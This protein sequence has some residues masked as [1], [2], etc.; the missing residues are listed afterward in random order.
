MSLRFLPVNRTHHPYI[1]IDTSTHS[2][3]R[4]YTICVV[5]NRKNSLDIRTK[6]E[7]G[8]LRWAEMVGGHRGIQ[9]E[10]NRTTVQSSK[11]IRIILKSTLCDMCVCVFDLLQP[12]CE[13]GVYN[14]GA[15]IRL[16]FRST[17]AAKKLNGVCV[18]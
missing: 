2:I 11:R 8:V 7:I 10:R 6:R 18:I 4:S 3:M 9:T 17:Q 14:D 12:Q 15:H 1:H 16:D 5:Q 13:C